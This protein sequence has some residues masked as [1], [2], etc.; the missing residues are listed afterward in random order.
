MIRMRMPAISDTKGPRLQV[1]FMTVSF[2]RRGWIRLKDTPFA[3]QRSVRQGTLH[4][5][6]DPEAA[7]N[8]SKAGWS[9]AP[10][11][12]GASVTTLSL[13][14]GQ[15]SVPCRPQSSVLSHRIRSRSPAHK[16]RSGSARS[17]MLAANT[18]CR[19]VQP[20]ASA[21]L[22]ASPNRLR[23]IMGIGLYWYS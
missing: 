7:G 5:P 2:V 11:G 17:Q 18:H 4:G 21:V 22:C 12:D 15:S 3:A 9:D 13:Q 8:T 10:P 19:R 14:R 20:W 16:D 6:A 1:I 23:L